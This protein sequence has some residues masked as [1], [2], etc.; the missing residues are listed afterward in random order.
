MDKNY[1]QKVTIF[2]LTAVSILLLIGFAAMSAIASINKERYLDASNEISLAYS[3][4]YDAGYN[5]AMHWRNH[6]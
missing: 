3:S 4:G 5:D 6:K 1:E 2:F